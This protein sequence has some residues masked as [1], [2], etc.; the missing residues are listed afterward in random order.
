MLQTEVVEAAR[1]QGRDLGHIPGITTKVRYFH[2]Y[3]KA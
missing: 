3:S 1:R 2:F